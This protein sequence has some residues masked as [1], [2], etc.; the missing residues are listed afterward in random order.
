M[1][2]IIR[3]E[4]INLIQ[5]KCL[6]IRRDIIRMIGGAGLG[7]PGGSLSAVEIVTSL[8]FNIMDVD[9]EN[10]RW[11]DRDRFILSK[12]HASALLYAVLAERGYFEIKKLKSF[13]IT[14][15]LP[16]HPD[17]S[18]VAGVEMT[19]GSLGHGLSVA[20][21][22]A[23]AGKYDNKK[24]YVYVLLGDGEIQEGQIWEAAMAVSHF[25][26]DNVIAFI[27]RNML[28]ID[29]TTEEVMSLEPV[30]SKWESFGWNVLEIDGHDIAEIITATNKAKNMKGKPTL[31][32]ANTVK[33]KGISYME[34]EVSW[35][36][37]APNKEEMALALKELETGGK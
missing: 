37:K 24:Y 33:G 11:E 32:I 6:N 21:G 18:K 17:M 29:D 34:N 27:D 30:A 28:Q 8:Y 5:Q 9:P 1:G 3:K 12:G 20:N 14:D 13:R 35:H 25:K 16:G 36:G 31:I 2:K 10:P 4:D 19:T 23:L 26:L 7:H 22:I 15:G